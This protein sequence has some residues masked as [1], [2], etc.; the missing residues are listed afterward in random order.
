MNEHAKSIASTKSALRG[1]VFHEEW[2]LN[3]VTRGGYEE[4]VVKNGSDVVGCLSF[5]TKKRMGLKTLRMPPFTH[6]LGPVV[7][8]GVGKPQTQMLRRLS[9]VRDLIDQLPQFDFFKQAL[10]SSIADGLAFQDRGFQAG[11]QYTF[12][13]DCC[14]D[15]KNIWDGMH[16]K[17][18]Q[19]IRRAEEKFLVAT[20]DDP[21]D[22]MRFYN[23]N[24]AARGRSPVVA[25]DTFPAAFVACQARDSGE[26]LSANWPDGK[27]AA[28]VFLVWGHGTM[29]YLL[30]TRAD[31]A[32]DN[33]S[34]S[35]LIWSAI[36]R[37]HNRGLMFDLDGVST[38]G[39]ARFLSG[40]GGR[41]QVR[42][43]VQRSSFAYGALQ[44]AKRQLIGGQADDTVAF[45]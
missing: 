3:A 14:D 32:G 40:F 36:K 26:I 39:I 27:P 30:S 19:H 33:G 25:L 29:Y 45:T 43:I 12:E 20:V 44:Y 4:V 10:N 9:I 1:T 38:S 41:L 17:T 18:R 31:D 22:F 11:M 34:V 2:W 21:N 23:R 42:T 5:V 24:L 6:V 13:I 37:A 35:L 7:D 15:L 8:A 28:M 16:F